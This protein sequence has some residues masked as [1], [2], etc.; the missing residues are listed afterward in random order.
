M[1]L[2]QC[3]NNCIGIRFNHVETSPTQYREQFKAV[4]HPNYV[5]VWQASEGSATS[6]VC[7]ARVHDLEPTVA[8]R[9][10]EHRKPGIDQRD[11]A[12]ALTFRGRRSRRVDS[13]TLNLKSNLIP[14]NLDSGGRTIC[15]LDELRW[16]PH[17]SI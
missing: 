6:K 15:Q 13:N 17:R 3:M 8:R 5:R 12:L 16:L 1:P 9:R 10:Y 2:Q 4:K 7:A 11:F 14:Y